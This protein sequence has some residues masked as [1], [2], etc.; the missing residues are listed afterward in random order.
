MSDGLTRRR[1]REGEGEKEKK[2][3]R[4]EE[5]ESGVYDEKS[6]KVLVREAAKEPRSNLNRTH[7]RNDFSLPLQAGACARSESPVNSLLQAKMYIL[8]HTVTA[9]KSSDRERI[10][11]NRSSRS[12]SFSFSLLL[13]LVSAASHFFL[14]SFFFALSLP[15]SLS[16]S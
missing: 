9:C 3:M 13:H 7:T 4:E 16:T 11:V 8:S 2:K 6:T 14:F 15:L 10:V 5:R 1:Q 12:R